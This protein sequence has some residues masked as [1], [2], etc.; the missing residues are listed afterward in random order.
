MTTFASTL[1]REIARMARKE[2]RE[3]FNAL[4]KAT[5]THRHEIA[6]LKRQLRD[7]QAALREANRRTDKAL[8]QMQKAGPAAVDRAADAGAAPRRGRRAVFDAA[9][10]KAQRERLGLT[11][12][13][14][15][16]Y[17][18]TSSLSVWK[19][20]SGQVVPRDRY[21]PAI[22]GLRTQGKREVTKALAATAS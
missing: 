8:Q 1:K 13:E 14:M 19:W 9:R 12:K 21:L 17:L 3:D 16:A 11:Q 6:T 2:L 5:A 7:T 10:F 20:E 15:A 4:R 18:G 22:L